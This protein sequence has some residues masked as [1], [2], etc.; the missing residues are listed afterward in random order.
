MSTQRRVPNSGINTSGRV[1]NTPSDPD[2]LWQRTR[3]VN[4]CSM[5]GSL[6]E[7][8]VLPSQ[9]Y[10]KIVCRT[11]CIGYQLHDAWT[12]GYLLKLCVVSFRF[13]NLI[14]V[15]F[16]LLGLRIPPKCYMLPMYHV[17][18]LSINNLC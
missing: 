9:S 6:R 12:K 7:S 8:S 18:K 17:S 3:Q 11:L 13:E 16:H 1:V 5:I 4:Y 15:N 10:Y 14:F 2:P